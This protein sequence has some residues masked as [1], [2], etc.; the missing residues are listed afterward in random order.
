MENLNLIGIQVKNMNEAIK[1]LGCTRETLK[2]ST[3]EI[4]FNGLTFH[5]FT[6]MS[7]NSK[8]FYYSVTAF[9]MDSK[10]DNNL[11]NWK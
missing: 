2:H 1:L 10:E 8:D 7:D 4:E 9:Y 3:K 11:N 5:I 6:Y